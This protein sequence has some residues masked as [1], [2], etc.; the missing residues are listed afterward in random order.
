MTSPIN[1]IDIKPGC[2]FSLIGSPNR[3][4]LRLLACDD[5]IVSPPMSAKA[6]VPSACL[7]TAD[8]ESVY[9]GSVYFFENDAQVIPLE[10]DLFDEEDLVASSYQI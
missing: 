10:I 2:L 3:I 4:F 8:G 6:N 9:R 1:I 5:N 7:K